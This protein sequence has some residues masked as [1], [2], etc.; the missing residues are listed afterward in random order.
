MSERLRLVTHNVWVGQPP[1]ELRANLSRL[2]ADTDWPHAIALQEARRLA[3]P[4]TGYVRV[5][6]D[7]VAEH[8]DDLGM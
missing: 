4:P 2:A 7:D 5:R 6:A 3:A 8:P 1:G